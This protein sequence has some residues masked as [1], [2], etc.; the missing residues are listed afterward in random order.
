MYQASSKT[1]I[2]GNVL[3]LV[4]SFT[5]DVSEPLFKYT[6]QTLMILNLLQLDV[7]QAII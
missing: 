6:L 3:H 1:H 5:A 7:T 2:F 4:M